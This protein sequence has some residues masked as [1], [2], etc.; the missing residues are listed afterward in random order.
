MMTVTVTQSNDPLLQTQHKPDSV[1]Q[2]KEGAPA[3]APVSSE[4]AAMFTHSILPI[5]RSHYLTP[6]RGWEAYERQ[7]QDFARRIRLPRKDWHR[8]TIPCFFSLDWDT[9][10]TWVRQYVAMP[11]RSAE[12]LSACDD[13]TFAEHGLMVTDPPPTPTGATDLLDALDLGK[14]GRHKQMFASLQQ[15]EESEHDREAYREQF[16]ASTGHDIVLRGRWKRSLSDDNFIT[17]LPQQYMPLS[18]VS[19]DIHSP[20][21]HMVGTLKRQVRKLLLGSDFNDVELWKG[22]TYQQFINKA[23]ASRGNGDDGKHHIGK[24][25]EKQVIICRIL[26]ADKGVEFPV[27]YTF[28]KPGPKKKTLHTVCGTAGGWIKDTKWT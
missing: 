19:A 17:V 5:L 9:R 8:V 16:Y 23:V 4:L 26:A 11:G 25:V 14:R 22:R 10:H 24:S 15:A 1:L 20:V 2:S 27:R 7:C 18:K 3:Q 21:E 13:A 28:G 6:D 12:H